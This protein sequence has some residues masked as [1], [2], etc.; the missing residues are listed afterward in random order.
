[1]SA[2]SFFF[3]CHATTSLH[4]SSL[5]NQYRA[6]PV[7]KS[8]FSPLRLLPDLR[9]PIQKSARNLVRWQQHLLVKI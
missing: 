4:L 1:M 7:V 6:L 9:V 5:P 3:Y 2:T 8:T